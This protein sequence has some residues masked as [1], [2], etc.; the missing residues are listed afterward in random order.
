M[1]YYSNLDEQYIF[2]LLE[3]TGTLQDQQLKPACYL[4]AAHD[5]F[6]QVSD[7]LN[8]ASNRSNLLS[9]WLRELVGV[10]D[11]SPDLLILESTIST[12]TDG[13]AKKVLKAWRWAAW[14]A[15]YQ[16]LSN[17]RSFYN[18][19]NRTKIADKHNQL[20]KKRMPTVKSFQ[21]YQQ[22]SDSQSHS[23]TVESINPHLGY[24]LVTDEEDFKYFNSKSERSKAIKQYLKNKMDYTIP[25]N[26]QQHKEHIAIVEEKAGRR[27]PLKLAKWKARPIFEAASSWKEL[28]EKLWEWRWTIHPL[29]RGAV[30]FDGKY[31]SR[32]KDIK[33]KFALERLEEK[34]GPIL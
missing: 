20:I 18:E 19:Q 3:P 13:D 1:N 17:Q 15:G 29:P 12:Y 26:P 23:Y 16:L 24:S 31:P 10:T 30:L 9:R 25:K 14:I 6:A 28:K 7:L 22:D 4:G 32:L 21:Y 5:P 34:F 8:N 27:H 33:P 11:N 2:V